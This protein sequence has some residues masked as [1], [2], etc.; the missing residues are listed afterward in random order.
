M[1][2]ELTPTSETPKPG[3]NGIDSEKANMYADSIHKLLD[4][5]ETMRGE[6]MA[7]IKDIYESAKDNAGI[8]KKLFRMSIAEERA[9]RKRD[10]RE[11]DLEESE[12]NELDQL[13]HAL[14]ML[15]DTPLGQAAM[16]NA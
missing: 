2:E 15:E 14:G 16:G 9:K 11:A 4:E 1:A 8:P 5:M 12:R 6:T 7:E 3:H 10:A 13:R